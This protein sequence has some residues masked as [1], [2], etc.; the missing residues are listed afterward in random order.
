MYRGNTPDGAKM[1]VCKRDYEAD[2]KRLKASIDNNKEFTQAIKNFVDCNEF[3]QIEDFKD[4][5]TFFAVYGSLSMKIPSME[6]EYDRLLE[7]LEK[8]S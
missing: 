1:A 6:K 2:A 4:R 5:K 8:E 7:E 3:H